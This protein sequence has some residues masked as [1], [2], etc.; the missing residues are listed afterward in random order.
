MIKGKH[1]MDYTL[2]ELNCTKCAWCMEF[3]LDEVACL[4]G[5]KNNEPIC[6]FCCDLPCCNDY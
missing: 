1:L 3:S 2:E 5:L 4:T 6:A